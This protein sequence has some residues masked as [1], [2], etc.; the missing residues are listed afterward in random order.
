M[1][2]PFRRTVLNVDLGELKVPRALFIFSRRRGWQLLS[3]MVF[4]F[5]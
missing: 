5:F 4:V 3:E 2:V 1:V